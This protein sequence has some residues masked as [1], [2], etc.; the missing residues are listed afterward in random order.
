MKFCAT[1]KSR[2]NAD[3]GQKKAPA[4]PVYWEGESLQEASKAALD[5]IA[6]NGLGGGNWPAAVISYVTGGD[7][8]EISY[9]GRVWPVGGCVHGVKPIYTP[10]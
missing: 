1:F 7:V 6:A 4:G 3:F 2:P 8:G 9:N 10:N 5:Y